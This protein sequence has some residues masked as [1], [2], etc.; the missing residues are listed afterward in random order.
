VSFRTVIRSAIAVL[1]VAAALP[2]AA[3][4][5]DASQ[6]EPFPNVS[7]WSD[8]THDSVSRYVANEL[9]GDWNGFIATLERYQEKVRAAQQSGRTIKV[10][11]KGRPVTL[12][13][14]KLDVFVHAS[15]WRLDVVKCLARETMADA[16]NAEALQAF[17]TAAGGSATTSTSEAA[18]QARNSSTD[19][20]GLLSAAVGALAPGSDNG[21]GA[22]E[23]GTIRSTSMDMRVESLCSG[24][25]AMFR[26]T[27]VGG[28]WPDMGRVALYKLDGGEPVQLSARDIRFAEGQMSTFRIRT[29]RVKGNRFALWV[30]P[31][32]E[33]RPQGWDATVTC[34]N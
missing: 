20:S 18:K 28:Q 15:D 9:D 5:A 29:D 4:D 32:W 30:D 8:L 11:H 23:F 34:G 25:V 31:K 6:C 2:F 19:Q 17:A 14:H 22:V 26:M 7:L 1:G 12:G 33:R 24:G 27:N 16:A 3:A 10:S 13:G 21:V